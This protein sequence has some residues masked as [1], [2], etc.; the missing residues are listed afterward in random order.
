[1]AGGVITPVELSENEQEVNITFSGAEEIVFGYSTKLEAIISYMDPDLHY[2]D[3]DNLPNLKTILFGAANGLYSFDVSHNPLLEN[4]R[5]ANSH[6]HTLDVTQNPLLT[7][8]EIYSNS[9]VTIDLSHN[10]LLETLD[11]HTNFLTTLNL[12]SNPALSTLYCDNNDLHTIFLPNTDPDLNL[13]LMICDNLNLT[14]I[15][16]MAMNN[17]NVG[18]GHFTIMSPSPSQDNNP[19]YTYHL[20]PLSDADFEGGTYSGGNVT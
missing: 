2:V 10:P 19:S 1:M 13:S 3:V 9:L 4:L 17:P 14:D 20:K 18:T 16:T 11:C 7:T 15:Y 6:L 12:T 8:L 5:I